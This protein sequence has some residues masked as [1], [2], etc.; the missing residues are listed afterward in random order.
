M[1][2]RPHGYAR[3]K[4]DGCRC[5][6]CGWAGAAYRDAREQAIR[7][8]TWQPFVDATPA[9]EHLHQL[10]LAGIGSRGIATLAGLDRKTIRALLNGRTD[11]GTPPPTQI[12]PATAAAILNVELT[13]DVLPG[14]LLVDATG[15][16][17]RLQALVRRGWPKARIAAQLGM[18]L[19]N[20]ISLLD[21]DR[22][23]AATARAVAE[24]YP[25]LEN[26]DPIA[27]G[28]MPG[29]ALRTA[30]TARYLH[31]ALPAAWDEDT[32]DDPDAHPDHTG[33]CGTADGYR[34]HVNQFILPACKPCRVAHKQEREQRLKPLKVA[35]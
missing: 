31:W 28:V 10:V 15:T 34:L 6:T 29:T 27:H 35:A 26:T 25:R 5:Y 7:R 13:L 1:T 23:T 2:E 24:L 14:H 18:T 8:G 16:V 3:Y 30:N 19:S 33:A 11:H 9:R 20:F 22:V 32:I 12:R 21:R 17:R 4:L